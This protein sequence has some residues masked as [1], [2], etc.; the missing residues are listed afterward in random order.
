MNRFLK[1]GAIGVIGLCILCGS[2]R[3]I[4]H[5]SITY[6][7]EFYQ[8]RL[9]L[10]DA[11]LES[12]A[13][14]FVFNSANMLNAIKRK[15]KWSASFTEEQ[16]NGWLEKRISRD[17]PGAIPI[18]GYYPRVELE[19][20]RISFAMEYCPEDFESI[21]WAQLRVSISPPGCYHVI[22]EKAKLGV[23]PISNAMIRNDLERNLKKVNIPYEIK[24]TDKGEIEL[25]FD[26]RE[27]DS[28]NDWQTDPLIYRN[29]KVTIEQL[30]V[31][32]GE[33]RISGTSKNLVRD[34]E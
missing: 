12:A 9:K 14:D 13:K 2:C 20:D 6:Y 34:E 26:W 25:V 7:P 23:I 19:Q 29:R 28:E 27:I 32:P 16:I 24:Q 30:D 33:I 21:V 11:Q 31:L 10:E 18:G 22:I 1:F 17:L 4:Y 3:Y 15:N 8:Q 5:K